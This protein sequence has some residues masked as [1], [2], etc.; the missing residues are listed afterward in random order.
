MTLIVFRKTPEKLKHYINV[1]AI[2]KN[3]KYILQNCVVPQG[4]H[5]IFI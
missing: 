3:I 5:A 1:R 2:F 4:I